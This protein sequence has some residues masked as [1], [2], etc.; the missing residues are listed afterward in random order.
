MGLGAVGCDRVDRARFPWAESAATLVGPES[1]ALRGGG[2]AEGAGADPAIRA[3]AV[4]RP[5]AR[6][7]ERGPGRS[8]PGAAGR[9]AGWQGSSDPISV[10][11]PP[12]KWR[13][14]GGHV[15]MRTVR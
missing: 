2:A 15:A 5:L 4:G 7:G 12:D 1:E 14:S 10:R 13:T 3:R 6:G 11:R 9:P 8:S